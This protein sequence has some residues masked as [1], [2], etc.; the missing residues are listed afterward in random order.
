MV[1][2]I[3][4]NKWDHSSIARKCKKPEGNDEELLLEESVY[5]TPRLPTPPEEH[6]KKHPL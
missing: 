6:Q 3:L 2:K 5:M 1:T 4:K